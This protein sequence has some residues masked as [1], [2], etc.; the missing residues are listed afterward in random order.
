L[1]STIVDSLA[2]PDTSSAVAARSQH[3]RRRGPSESPVILL[4]QEQVPLGLPLLLPQEQV[5]LG[6]LLLLPQ[7]Q[8]PLGLPCVFFSASGAGQPLDV[9]GTVWI[10]ICWCAGTG[11]IQIC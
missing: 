1:T 3:R 8:V 10:Q 6:L 5:P 4:P 9:S 2:F 7:E 11:W